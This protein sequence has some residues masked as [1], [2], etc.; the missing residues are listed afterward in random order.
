MDDETLMMRAVMKMSTYVVE[1]T[2]II[3]NPC[4]LLHI[5]PSSGIKEFEPR[6]PKRSMDKED[7]TVARVCT[8]PTLLDAIRGYAVTIKD[9][10]RG[11]AH[12]A[13]DD[14]FKG[15]Y[16][17]YAFPKVTHLKPNEKLAPISKWCDERW[18]I[19][20]RQ[21]NQKYPAK[22][23]GKMFFPRVEVDKEGWFGE[24]EIYIQ[25]EDLPNG[26][27]LEFSDKIL[28]GKGCHAV[29]VK[30][31]GA[32]LL[33]GDLLEVL[34]HKVIPLGQYYKAKNVKAELLSFNVPAY[35]DW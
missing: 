32:Y 3:V 22:I 12:C 21:A 16:Y 34:S 19:N 4:T 6:K 33:K 20:F 14:D 5:S 29:V 30:N 24:V 10:M 17:I 11:K 23:V 13:G 18:L 25:L 2:E 26:E 15:G 9:A 35:L 28:L 31:L 27:L 8:S 1:N 7:L